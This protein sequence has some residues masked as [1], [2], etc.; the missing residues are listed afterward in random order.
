MKQLFLIVSLALSI[1]G[2]GAFLASHLLD[3][4]RARPVP[5]PQTVLP[6]INPPDGKYVQRA[7][8]GAALMASSGLVL[9]GDNFRYTYHSDTYEASGHM[10]CSGTV[11][12]DERY[13]YLDGG[14]IPYRRWLPGVDR[15]TPF[16]R[17]VDG[18]EGLVLYWETLFSVVERDALAKFFDPTFDISS[19]PR[20][21]EDDLYRLTKL[22][23]I[24]RKKDELV[25][26]LE[27]RSANEALL[28]FSGPG[29]H[30]GGVVI[31]KKQEETWVMTRKLDAT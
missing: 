18:P 1:G 10:D 14:G 21:K 24:Y 30:G 7:P 12:R 31:F 13:L 2:G 9:S 15:G 8:P 16:L 20:G 17:S 22:F 5:S 27:Y 4:S 3:S 29:L 28:Y 6:R 19:I 23:A 11:A 26:R 25:R